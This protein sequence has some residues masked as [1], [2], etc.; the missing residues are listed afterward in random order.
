LTSFLLVFHAIWTFAFNGLLFQI[1]LVG[2][3]TNISEVNALARQV[4]EA[5][6]KG[7]VLADDRLD[8]VI[9]AGQE[10][11][12]QPFEYT[13]LYT[14]GLWDITPFTQEIASHKFSLI[15]IRSAY[16]YER[17]PIPIFE[18]IQRNY[19]CTMQ[20]KMLVCQP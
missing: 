10:I 3:W 19:T 12:Y 11:E 14:A 8:L 20:T 17:W 5:A 9:L 15:L 7:P 1:P 6:H 4:Q 18:A 16:R 2:L 13:Q